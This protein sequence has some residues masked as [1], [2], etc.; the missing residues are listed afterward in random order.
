MPS[1]RPNSATTT[2]AKNM[3]SQKE[4]AHKARIEAASDLTELSPALLR[5]LVQQLAIFAEEAYIDVADLM[6]RARREGLS[7]DDE[8]V[9]FTRK[10]L[11]HVA[12][13]MRLA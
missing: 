4:R 8:R 6:D 9:H 7:D 1:P 12:M 3:L 13:A 11:W 5:L 2:G 10:V